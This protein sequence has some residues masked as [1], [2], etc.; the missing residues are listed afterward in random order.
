MAEDTKDRKKEAPKI[1][2]IQAKIASLEAFVNMM[3]G[4]S[5]IGTTGKAILD[6]RRDFLA[7]LKSLKK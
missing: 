3:E 4:K 5:G 2:P 1:P 6:E 7:F